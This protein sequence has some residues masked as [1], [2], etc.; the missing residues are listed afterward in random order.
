MHDT[1]EGIRAGTTSDALGQLDTLVQL[2]EG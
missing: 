2:G 1:D